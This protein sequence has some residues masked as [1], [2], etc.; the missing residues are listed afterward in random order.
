MS[1]EDKTAEY[2]KNLEKLGVELSKI[3]YDFKIK[4][5]SSENY[6]EKRI[7]EF[8]N[9]HEKTIEYFTMVY[10]LMNL[11]DE[12][13]A[14]MFIFRLSKLKQLGKKLLE[15]MKAIKENPTAMD[16]KDMQ[17]SKWKK[18][19]R[20]K[21]VQSNLDCLNHEKRMNVFFKEFYEKHLHGKTK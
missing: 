14:G 9:Y 17:Q 12:E 7:Q 2:T 3:Q 21:L 1:S 15:A 13:Q 11:T 19:L 10:S 20:E 4:D 16:P 18:D 8:C 5:T 6:W